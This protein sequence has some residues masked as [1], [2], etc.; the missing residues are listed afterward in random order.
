MVEDNII[1]TRNIVTSLDTSGPEWTEGF[2]DDGWLMLSSKLSI[3][4][5]AQVEFDLYLP[6][7]DDLDDLKKRVFLYVDGS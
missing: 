6:G 3:V 4:N 5:A 7:S 2:Y 1:K